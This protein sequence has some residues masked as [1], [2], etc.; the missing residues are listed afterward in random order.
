MANHA[1]SNDSAQK[2]KKN[3]INNS[4]YL[5]IRLDVGWHVNDFFAELNSKLHFRQLLFIHSQTPLV[6]VTVTLIRTTEIYV[7]IL[8]VSNSK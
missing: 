1:V 4:C 5:R 2:W 7:K 3:L 8:A 6:V